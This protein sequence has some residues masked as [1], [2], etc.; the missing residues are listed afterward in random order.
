MKRFSSLAE[1]LDTYQKYVKIANRIPMT[2][3]FGYSAPSNEK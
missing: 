2:K 1:K 3:I